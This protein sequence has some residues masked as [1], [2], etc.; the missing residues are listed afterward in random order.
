MLRSAPSSGKVD[1]QQ[2]ERG[3]GDHAGRDERRHAGQPETAP[4]PRPASSAMPWSGFARPAGSSARRAKHADRRD[5]SER[6]Q[7][8]ASAAPSMQPPTQPTMQGPSPLSDRGGRPC[9]GRTRPRARAHSPTRTASIWWLGH[10]EH[11]AGA[12]EDGEA[13]QRERRMRARPTNRPQP[14]RISAAPIQTR[15]HRCRG[16]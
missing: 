10:A 4:P 1:H 13:E 16:R 6:E 5:Q 12:E 7:L 15:A 3:D 8:A 9:N 14:A 2:I 11:V